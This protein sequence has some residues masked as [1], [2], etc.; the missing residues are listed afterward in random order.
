[1]SLDGWNRYCCA[2]AERASGDDG[3]G[4]SEGGMPKVG[5]VPLF[6]RSTK[7]VSTMA[8]RKSKVYSDVS[9]TARRYSPERGDRLLSSPMPPKS[10]EEAD[11]GSMVQDLA[12]LKR[13]GKDMERVKT[14]QELQEEG[15]VSDPIQH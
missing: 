7:E 9:P 4:A 5:L 6:R 10:V 14:G 8:Y 1:M 12:D 2:K 13:L 11:N 15:F 3:G